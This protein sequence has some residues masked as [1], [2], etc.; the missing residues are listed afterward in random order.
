MSY[1]FGNNFK[2]TLFGQSHS[3]E[4]G[5]VIDGVKTGYKINYDLIEKI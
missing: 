1:S 5:I 2:I 4:I 3:K